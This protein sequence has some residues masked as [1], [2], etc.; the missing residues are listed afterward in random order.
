MPLLVAP[1]E[2]PVQSG[3][4]WMPAVSGRLS[5]TRKISELSGSEICAVPALQSSA[6][7]AAV[8]TVLMTHVLVGVLLGFGIGS[9]AP[10]KQPGSVQFL[11]LP[12]CAELV[13]PS[14]AVVALAQPSIWVIDCAVSGVMAGN[15]TVFPPPPK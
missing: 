15:G 12:V 5:P 13:D 7:E 11:M 9:G 1:G 2:P 6:P 14:V 8:E 3:H 4:G 10:K